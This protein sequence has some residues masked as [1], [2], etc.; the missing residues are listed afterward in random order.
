MTFFRKLQGRLGGKEILSFYQEAPKHNFNFCYLNCNKNYII[1]QIDHLFRGEK[2]IMFSN[3]EKFIIHKAEEPCGPSATELS[4]IP[5]PQHH[6]M[7]FIKETYQKQK[8]LS[9]AFAILAKHNLF[10]EN[11]FCVPFPN[12]HLAD[13]CSFFL[14]RFGKNDN[15]DSRYIK[16]CNF[17]QKKGIKLPK[18]S[19]K[20]PV[21]QKYLC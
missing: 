10:D 19:I 9:V 12:I 8:Y 15:T 5:S 3:S 7:E 2:V 17:L 6:V 14:N 13:V 18:I 16:F 4:E 20:N 21:A 1:N 11:L